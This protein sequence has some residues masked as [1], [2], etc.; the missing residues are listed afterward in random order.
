MATMDILLGIFVSTIIG[1]VCL[2]QYFKR[3]RGRPNLPPGSLGLPVIGETLSFYRALRSN[4]LFE[5][6][7]GKRVQKHGKVFK[8]GLMGSPTVVFTGAV[9]NRFLMA[10]EFKLVVSSW[11]KSTIDLMGSGSIMEKQGSEHRCLRGVVMAC[12]RGALSETFVGKMSSVMERHFASHWKGESVVCV[13]PLTKLLTFSC[14]C[15]FF[16]GLE[17]DEQ[18]EDFLK[19]FKIVLAGSLSIPFDFPGTRYRRAMTLDGT[20]A[21]AHR[22]ESIVVNVDND[23]KTPVLIKRRR[24]PKSSSAPSMVSMSF[25]GIPGAA[26]MARPQVSSASSIVRHAVIGVVVYMSS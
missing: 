18:V 19:L 7:F 5:D 23:E 10:N 16:L 2:N 8:T 21:R 25:S 15:S 20:D 4:R 17:D 14:V 24:V 22:S 13:F 26:A 11:P 1:F 12:F 3:Y 6:F 9:G